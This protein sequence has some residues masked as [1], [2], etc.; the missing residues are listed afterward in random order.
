MAQIEEVTGLSHL[1]GSEGVAV[2]DERTFGL[3]ESFDRQVSDV[4]GVEEMRKVPFQ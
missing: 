3:G 1:V 2:L 4:V